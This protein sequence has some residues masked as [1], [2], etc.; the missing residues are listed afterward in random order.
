VVITVVAAAVAV[1]EGLPLIR[2]VTPSLP[3]PRPLWRRAYL[4]WNTAS[5][6]SWCGSW[7]TC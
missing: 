7:R 1:A 6:S 5:S 4:T 2:C 3:T